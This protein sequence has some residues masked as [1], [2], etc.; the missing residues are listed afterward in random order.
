MDRRED[1][2]LLSG[3]GC[4]TGSVGPLPAE[5]EA[6]TNAEAAAAR[7][8]YRA[9][10]IDAAEYLKKGSQVYIEGSLRTRKWQDKSGT[11]RYS[12][13][14]IETL[15]ELARSMHMEIIAEGVE[16]LSQL[17][18]LRKLNCKYGQG[19]LFAKPAAAATFSACDGRVPAV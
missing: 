8:D 16:T 7:S 13:T 3:A 19:Y 11:E 4:G 9:A 15:I 17:S 5:P 1:V 12:T 18:Q 2:L 14:I 6:D 10:F